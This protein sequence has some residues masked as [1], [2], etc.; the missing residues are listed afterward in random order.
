MKQQLMSSSGA[1][2]GRIVDQRAQR[3]V[4]RQVDREIAVHEGLGQI[5]ARDIDLIVGLGMHAQS[6][7][8]S[9]LAHRASL[10]AIYGEDAMPSLDNIQM[11]TNIAVGQR[12]LQFANEVTR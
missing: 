3:Q 9:M 8:T 11:I 4:A 6:R 1:L 12:V 2:T 7:V 10:A 5:A